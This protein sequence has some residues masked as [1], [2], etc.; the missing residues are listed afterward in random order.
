MK[1]KEEDARLSRAAESNQ[2]F[3]AKRDLICYL[4]RDNLCQLS[5]Q[6]VST[7]G[8]EGGSWESA[9]ATV[10]VYPAHAR[11]VKATSSS[12]FKMEYRPKKWQ[13]RVKA[14]QAKVTESHQEWK[15]ALTHSKESKTQRVPFSEVPFQFWLKGTGSTKQH[16]STDGSDQISCWPVC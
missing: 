10:Q 15:M 13:A 5:P 6:A 9:F 3:L 2:R 14:K 8:R 12:L 11:L 7:C 1:V 4:I 16:G